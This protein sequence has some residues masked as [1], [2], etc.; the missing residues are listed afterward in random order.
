VSSAGDTNIRGV[1]LTAAEKLLRQED[2]P[3]PP[4]D[5]LITHRGENQSETTS[6][7]AAKISQEQSQLLDTTQA[8]TDWGGAVVA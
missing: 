1:S 6:T 7:R 4:P 5:T 8:T 3:P 2:P